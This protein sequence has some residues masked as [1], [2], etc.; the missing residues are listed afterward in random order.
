MQLETT[1]VKLRL[2]AADDILPGDIEG[3]DVLKEIKLHKG[4][5]RRDE[6]GEFIS[7][8]FDAHEFKFRPGKAIT[9]GKLVANALRRSSA[10]MIGP[11]YLNGPIA[12]MLVVE[13]EFELGEESSTPMTPT[14]CPVCFEEQKTLPRLSRHLDK[15]K[16]T[17]P[18]LFEKEPDENE[19]SESREPVDGADEV[20]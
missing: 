17:H 11:D 14:T 15:H 19:E 9:V 20:S 16:K 3:K 18:E 7:V 4:L 10:I 13:K 5:R 6:H 8:M 12:P 1:Q 2:V